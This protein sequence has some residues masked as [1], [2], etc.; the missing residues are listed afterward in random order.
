MY[1]VY[2]DEVVRWRSSR[3]RTL[4]PPATRDQILDLRARVKV[5]L[6]CTVPPAYEEFLA[7]SNGLE[8]NGL[9]VYACA[10]AADGASPVPGFV[11]A[12]LAW[13]RDDYFVTILVFAESAH[14]LY[15]Y[16]LDERR[17]HVLDRR[18]CGVQH[19]FAAWQGVLRAA[20]AKHRPGPAL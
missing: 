10:P 1:E 17:H 19:S 14:S 8:S 2:L 18:T 20:L 5:R 16:D 7:R 9:V 4:P 11:E 12:N 6:G 13:R 15:V 3:G